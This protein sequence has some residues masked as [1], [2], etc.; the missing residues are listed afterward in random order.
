M[1]YAFF[2]LWLHTKMATESSAW[3]GRNDFLTESEFFFRS[4]KTH[5][6]CFG[7]KVVAYHLTI[8]VVLAL[9][10][11]DLLTLQQSP[12][13]VW[14]GMQEFPVFPPWG[15]GSGVVSWRGGAGRCHQKCSQHGT[16]SPS[17]QALIRAPLTGEGCK[18]LSVIHSCTTQTM[19]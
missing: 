9:S 14:G 1:K 7:K 3:S 8:T 19:I 6:Q 4:P 5:N 17:Q 11:K 15:P 18:A 10:H 2:S 16:A 13:Q 12:V